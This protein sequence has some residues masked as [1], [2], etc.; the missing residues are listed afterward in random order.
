[1]A[2]EVVNVT[3]TFYASSAGGVTTPAAGQID[4]YASDILWSTSD[5]F[6]GIVNP[7]G[8]NFNASGTI[9]PVGLLAMDNPGFSGNWYWVAIITSNGTIFPARKLLINFANGATQDLST[10]LAASTIVNF[11]P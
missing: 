2:L 10:L 1:M 6:V 4:F 3:G 9:Q 11:T 7:T 5:A 8:T